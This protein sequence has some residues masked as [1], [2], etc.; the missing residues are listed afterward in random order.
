MEELIRLGA[1][2]PGSNPEVDEAIR[3]QPALEAFLNQHVEETT[4]IPQG[5]AAL[6]R[7]LG[8]SE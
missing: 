3:V 7:A 8:G 1:Y 6:A 4:S 5:F 2:A